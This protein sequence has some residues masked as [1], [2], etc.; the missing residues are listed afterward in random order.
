MSGELVKF[1]PITEV[2]R[3]YASKSNSNYGVQSFIV[4]YSDGDMRSPHTREKN[5][6]VASTVLVV[7]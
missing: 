6:W 4:T 3:G 5:Y 7:E 2:S 1:Y